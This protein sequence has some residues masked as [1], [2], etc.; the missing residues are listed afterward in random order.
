[1]GYPSHVQE[2]KR[3][4]ISSHSITIK[5]ANT[6]DSASE[7]VSDVRSTQTIL[8]NDVGNKTAITLQCIFQP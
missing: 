4:T 5:K 6:F 3:V 2:L 8:K 7:T 1:M